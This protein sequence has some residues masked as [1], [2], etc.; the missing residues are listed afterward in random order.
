M[1]K[2][3]IK[4]GFFEMQMNI[5][6]STTLIDAKAHPEKYPGLIVRVWGMSAYF[7]ELPDSYKELLINR[8]IAAEKAA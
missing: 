3:T 6:S 7:N 2:Q 8:A 5:M 1:I 4:Q